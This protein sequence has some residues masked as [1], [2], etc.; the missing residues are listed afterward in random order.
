M[1]F[2]L[3]PKSVTL[4]DLEVEWRT[5]HYFC[6]ILPISVALGP[7]RLRQSGWILTHIVCDKIVTKMSSD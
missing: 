4:N 7:I 6:V 1:G 2:R 3:V 5:G